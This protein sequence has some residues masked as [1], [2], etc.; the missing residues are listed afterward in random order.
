MRL[1]CT[2]VW[3]IFFVFA[4]E[5]DWDRESQRDVFV[6]FCVDLQF[7]LEWDFLTCADGDDLAAMIMSKN[8]IKEE[9]WSRRRSLSLTVNVHTEQQQQQ[10]QRYFALS[11]P[12]VIVKFMMMQCYNFPLCNCNFSRFLS[13]ARLSVCSWNDI[14][15]I[16]Q[17]C[18]WTKRQQ[19]RRKSK[20]WG[21]DLSFYAKKKTREKRNV[22]GCDCR[23]L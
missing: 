13:F 20:E 17:P 21:R 6:C 16:Q 9:I 22:I 18:V 23:Q 3:R 19:P 1:S 12:Y 8:I 4:I 11:N 2:R 10:Q 14:F 7:L 15:S 5:T